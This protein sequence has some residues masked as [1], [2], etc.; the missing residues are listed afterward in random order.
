MSM[1][2]PGMQPMPREK[3]R[4]FRNWARGP[5]DRAMHF[6][7]QGA[8]AM[9]YSLC[10]KPCLVGALKGADGIGSYCASCQRRMP[11]YEAWAESQSREDKP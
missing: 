11:K 4:Q 1:H 3:P 8:A 6:Y 9:A 2:G 5:G 10:N 7:V